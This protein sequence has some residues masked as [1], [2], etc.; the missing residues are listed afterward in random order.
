MYML[1]LFF[2]N[3]LIVSTTFGFCFQDKI[4][5]AKN[6]D[7]IVIEASKMVTVLSIR[8]MT[9]KSIELEE[10]SIPTKSILQRPT[11]WS[12][13]VKNEAPGHTSWSVLDIDRATGE[14]IECYSFTHKAWIQLSPYQSVLVSLLQMP[15]TEVPISERRKIGLPPASGEMD[16]RKVW[17][18]PVCFEGKRIYSTNFDVYKTSWPKDQTNLSESVITFYFDNKTNFSMP[19]WIQIDTSHMQIALR[20]IDSGSFLVSPKTKIPKKSA[21]IFR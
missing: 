11:R 21:F 7:Y 13:W 1:R 6:G 19:F 4:N 15:L 18:P 12:E 3:L 5:E 20:T 16:T 8:S 14:I 2:V 10:V 9:E 17:S